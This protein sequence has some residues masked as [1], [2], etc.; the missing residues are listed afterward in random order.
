MVDVKVTPPG[1]SQVGWRMKPGDAV[2][3]EWD[4]KTRVNVTVDA[5]GSVLVT[6]ERQADAAADETH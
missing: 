6:G 5:D 1:Q 4:A 2:A 3:I